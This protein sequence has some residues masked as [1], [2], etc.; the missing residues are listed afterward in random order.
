MPDAP[1]PGFAMLYAAGV[2]LRREWEE[3]L[4]EVTFLERA[5]IFPGPFFQSVTRRL[6]IFGIRAHGIIFFVSLG[7]FAGSRIPRF[8][9]AERRRAVESSNGPHERGMALG[10]FTT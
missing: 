1:V 6:L 3:S 9:V 2:S 7:A 10:T 8:A 4:S 5:E